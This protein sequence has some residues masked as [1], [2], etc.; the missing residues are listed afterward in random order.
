MR[1]EIDGLCPEEETTEIDEIRVTV[2][3]TEDE[4]FVFPTIPRLAQAARA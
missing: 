2:A 1:A 4:R 3:T